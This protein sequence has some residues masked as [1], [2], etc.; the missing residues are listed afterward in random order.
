LLHAG[1]GG[2][3]FFINGFSVARV[4]QVCRNG[5]DTAFVQAIQHDG[6][7]YGAGGEQDATLPVRHGRSQRHS[8]HHAQN[9]QVNRS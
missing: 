7:E 1:F 8:R 5:L 4:N 2:K 3:H 9:R 6:V